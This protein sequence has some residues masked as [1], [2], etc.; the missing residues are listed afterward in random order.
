[1]KL[2]I[3]VLQ[4]NDTEPVSQS[5][6]QA[7]FRVTRIA[8]T[9]GFMRRGQSTFMIGVEDDQVTQAIEIIRASVSHATDDTAQS[10]I[11]FVLPVECYTHV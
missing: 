1:M 2:I 8:S 11:L 3:T 6:I 9:G 7:G 5:L 4:D 10:T